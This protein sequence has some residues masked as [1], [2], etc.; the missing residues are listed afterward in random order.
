M[1]VPQNL[2]GSAR[3]PFFWP[4]AVVQ[5]PTESPAGSTKPVG[6]TLAMAA[7]AAP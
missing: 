4:W 5:L 1:F 3:E 6:T 2:L 7:E